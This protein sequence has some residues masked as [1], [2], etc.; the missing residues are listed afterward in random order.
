MKPADVVEFLQITTENAT[1]SVRTLRKHG[2]RTAKIGN[3]VRC[4]LSDVL[5]FVERQLDTNEQ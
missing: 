3:E 1:A 5:A 4:T 2:L